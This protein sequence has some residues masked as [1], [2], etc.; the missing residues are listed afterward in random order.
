MKLVLVLFLSLSTLAGCGTV[1][2]VSAPCKRPANLSAY[3]ASDLPADVSAPSPD[4]RRD[5]PTMQNV[6][7]SA[8]EAH[9]AIDAI[10]LSDN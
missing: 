2:E 9:A 4:T 1:K 3:A 7:G 8:S 5:C 10:V 6:N